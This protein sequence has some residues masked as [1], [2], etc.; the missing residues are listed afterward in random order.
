MLSIFSV[1]QSFQQ[2]SQLLVTG[3]IPLNVKQHGTGLNV[4]KYVITVYVAKWL[5][6]TFFSF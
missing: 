3:T 2:N 6:N 1:S 5:Y 4:K